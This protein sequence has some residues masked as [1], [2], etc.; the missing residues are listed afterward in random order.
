MASIRFY[1]DN[2]DGK[3]VNKH[4]T[5]SDAYAMNLMEKIREA[6]WEEAKI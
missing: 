3:K 6:G 2:L 4:F 1:L 5:V